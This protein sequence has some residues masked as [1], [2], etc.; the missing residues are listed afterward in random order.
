[1]KA[2][3]GCAVFLLLTNPLP[4]L[5]DPIELANIKWPGGGGGSSGGFT[6][7]RLVLEGGGNPLDAA[8][9]QILDGGIVTTGGYQLFDNLI[10]PL[11][12]VSGTF[13]TDELTDPNFAGFAKTLTNGV[14]DFVEFWEMFVPG[15]SSPQAGAGGLYSGEFAL[16]GGHDFLG[17]IVTR[18]ILQVDSLD[19]S[20][21]PDGPHSVSVDARV[22]VEGVPVPEP[23]TLALFGGGLLALIAGQRGVGAPSRGWRRIR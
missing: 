9:F 3:F 19:S 4:A 20:S 10:F 5:A 1:M 11:G 12:H 2:I 15:P 18:I 22:I 23:S 21:L 6:G 7:I 8:A 14:D 13:Y 17:N 16:F